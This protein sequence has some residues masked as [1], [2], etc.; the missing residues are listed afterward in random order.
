MPRL[1]ERRYDVGVAQRKTLTQR[2]VAILRWIADG[3]PDGVMDGDSH[4]ISAAALRGRG[5]VGTSGHGPTWTAEIT[6]AGREY[7]TRV[8]GPDPPAPRQANVSVTQQLIND[9]VAA[10][11]SLRVPRKRWYDRDGVDYEN[12]V[13]LAERHRKVPAGNRLVV[14][15]I[16][17]E[18][19]IKLVDAPDCDARV[20]L[21]PVVVPRRVSRYHAAARQFRDRAERHEVSRDLVPRATR[22]VH[23]IAIEAERRGWAVRAPGASENGYGRM[24]WAGAKDGHLRILAEDQEF[25]LRLKEEGVRTR[26]TWEEEVT[27]YR[28]VSRDDPWY[29]DRDLPSGPYDA[30]AAGQLKLELFCSQYWIFGGRQSRWS[31]R[32]SWQLEERLPHLLREIAERIAEAKRIAEEKRV[33][34]KKAAEAARRKTEERERQWHILMDQARTRLVEADRAARLRAQ[35]EAWRQADELR[36]YCDALEAAHG[37]DPVTAGWLSWARAYA[38]SLDP[39][40]EPPAMPEPPEPTPEALQEHLPDGWSAYGPESEHRALR[41]I[42]PHAHR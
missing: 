9:V 25:W 11:G 3:C 35:A 5:L 28:H 22:I 19:E 33:A 6:E 23:A 12:R 10:G 21:V 13:R 20:D 42:S 39:L 24:S 41:S 18:L 29:R 38:V 8:D 40:A 27:R 2:Q 4:R 30:E 17:D 7:L 36:R 1:A 15:T 26:G 31:D 16:S 32:Q 37:D 34:A 14:S